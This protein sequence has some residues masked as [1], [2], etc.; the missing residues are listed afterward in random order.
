MA[1]KYYDEDANLDEL[2]D[3][4]VAVIGYGSQGHAHAQNL[5]D[6]GLDV[7]V[8]EVEGTPNYKAAV[9]DGFEPL[10]ASE[11]AQKASV[12]ALLVPDE[13]QKDVYENELVDHL[14]DEDMLIFGHG[15]NIRFYQIE[16]PENVDVVLV[17]PKGP[18][19]VVRQMYE[20][21]VGVPNLLGVNQDYS[22]RAKDRG[23][24]Y[25]KG[26]GGT[27][28][29]VLETTFK[30][31]TETDLFGEQVI[32]CGGLTH[33]IKAAFETLVDEGY[34]P[35]VAYFECLHE[36]KLITDLIY[37]SGIQGMRYS[38]SDTAEYGDLTRGPRVI[39]EET[40][41]EMKEI[42]SEIK[43]GEFAREWLTENQ[44]GRPVFK[45]L[46]EKHASHEVEDV[47][48][49]IRG[50]MDWLEDRFEE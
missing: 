18:G 7:V 42:L 5:R 17:A 43:S 21:G 37:E 20:E 1:K 34:Q 9:N 11:A 31:E 33:L 16:P 38:I 25:S 27:Q 26:I 22:G 36:L 35:E 46:R 8:A 41:E 2:K 6:S 3:E 50:M 10:S 39:D 47:G 15:F 40:K 13:V 23:L 30:E 19:H 14:E 48:R 12:I 44:T 49:E 28:A 29:G 4:T 24:A 45:S 32:L